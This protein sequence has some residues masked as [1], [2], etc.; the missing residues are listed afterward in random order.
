M[1]D[2][3]LLKTDQEMD[4]EKISYFLN[5]YRCMTEEALSYIVVAK[6]GF[7]SEEADYA[8]KIVLKERDTP[9]LQEEISETAEDLRA[10]FQYAQ[11]MEKTRELRENNMRKVWR[12]LYILNI[13]FG[14]ISML[15]V[16]REFG[17]FFV[18]IGL[19][20]CIYLEV[21]WLVWRF[22]LALFKMD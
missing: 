20:L 3:F 7:L 8:L 19:F 13:V 2:M 1:S 11:R 4:E 5:R 14:L 10:Q 16:G 15:L 12:I 17:G 18:L 9:R 22:V 21:R 6:K